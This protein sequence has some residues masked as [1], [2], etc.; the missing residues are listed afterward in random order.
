M[1]EKLTETPA[2]P[3]TRPDWNDPA[4]RFPNTK[5]T[6]TPH[7]VDRTPDPRHV[8]RYPSLFSAEQRDAAARAI[9]GEIAPPP[10]MDLND[11]SNAAQ[12]AAFKI[13]AEKAGLDAAEANRLLAHLTG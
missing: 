9:V 11:P 8:V 13:A 6:L 12:F 4:T 2:L 3:N 5:F 10:G 1:S 7:V